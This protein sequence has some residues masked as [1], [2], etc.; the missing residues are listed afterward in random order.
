VIWSILTDINRFMESLKWVDDTYSAKHKSEDPKTLRAGYHDNL[1]LY[2]SNQAPVTKS[3]K[4]SPWQGIDVF[5]LR[6]GKKAV[7]SISVYIFAHI[8]Y[9]GKFI[10]PLLSFYTFDK[11]VGNKPAVL[12]FASGLVLPK[13]YL[14]RFLQIYFGSRSMTREL[15]SPYALPWRRDID[16]LQL[17]PYFSRVHFSSQQ[18]K[19]FFFEREGVLFGFGL[20]FFLLIRIP[21]FGVLAYGVAEAS[22][23]Y[24]ITKITDPPPPPE[25]DSGTNPA[26]VEDQTEWHQ[27]KDVLQAALTHLDKVNVRTSSRGENPL[28]TELPRK[29]FT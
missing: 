5:L 2:F 14:I 28:S 6:Y 13:H 12:I 29:K 21:I 10:L 26:F 4:V 16:S 25:G 11:A 8:P 20:A 7:L 3:R 15:V 27:K 19:R 22:T 1:K 17:E 24:L 9:V 23:A 18:K